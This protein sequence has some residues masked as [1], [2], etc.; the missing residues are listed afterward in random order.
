[1]EALEISSKGF[2]S[3]RI[4]WGPRAS[5]VIKFSRQDKRSGRVGLQ[6]TGWGTAP[7]NVDVPTQCKYEIRRGGWHQ[8]RLR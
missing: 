7:G 2:N 1:M 5:P 6:G 8:K 4:Y 3:T